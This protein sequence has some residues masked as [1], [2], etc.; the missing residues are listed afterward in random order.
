MLLFI[1]G[2]PSQARSYSIVRNMSA[3]AKVHLGDAPYSFVMDGP[4]ENHRLELRRQLDPPRCLVWLYRL[5]HWQRWWIE[6]L[7]TFRVTRVEYYY[8]GRV[9][10]DLVDAACHEMESR[11]LPEDA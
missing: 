4:G 6:P 1:D 9:S 2:Q 11:I 10:V 7:G 3:C 5:L 8:G